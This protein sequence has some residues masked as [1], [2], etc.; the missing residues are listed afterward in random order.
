MKILRQSVADRSM[1]AGPRSRQAAL[2]R[3]DRAN[4]LGKRLCGLACK[5]FS[6]FDQDR[7]K[8][9]GEGAIMGGRGRKDQRG[10]HTWLS[11]DRLGIRLLST[12][13][14]RRPR[15]VDATGPSNEGR[16]TKS[17]RNVPTNRTTP[18]ANVRTVSA[19]A[20]QRRMA[21]KSW[22]TVAVKVASAS[23]S[24]A[25]PS[26][27]TF[28]GLWLDEAA[29]IPAL[30]AVAPATGVSSRPAS[31]PEAPHPPLPRVRGASAEVSS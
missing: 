20:W 7:A 13:P 26:S 27:S 16:R 21:A 24:A 9:V 23:R 22:P 10:S 30:A 4:P 6:S 14:F 2:R 1:T 11:F 3:C 18:A 19:P 31:R 17:C 25:A 29:R 12:A 28:D 8:H 15:T 5:Q